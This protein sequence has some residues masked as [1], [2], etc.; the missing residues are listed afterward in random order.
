MPRRL[1]LGKS[2]EPARP[3]SDITRLVRIT[4]YEIRDGVMARVSLGTIRRGRFHKEKVAIK[5][6]NGGSSSPGRAFTASL[7]KMLEESSRTWSRVD[8]PNLVPFYGVAY[9]LFYM[10][11]LVY[12]FYAHGNIMSY[13]ENKWPGDVDKDTSD[14]TTTILRLMT[15]VAKG[16]EYLHTFNPPI[17]HG[18]VRGASIFIDDNDRA[19]LCDYGL[20]LSMPEDLPDYVFARPVGV[21]RWMAPEIMSTL[22]HEEKYGPPMGRTKLTDIYAYAM[23]ILEVYTG[24]PPFA[25]LVTDAKGTHPI[26]RIDADAVKIVLEGGRPPL[27]ESIRSIEALRDLVERAWDMTPG[28]R[29]DATEIVRILELMAHKAPEEVQLA[30]TPDPPGGARVSGKV[31][32]VFH[33]LV[34]GPWG[35]IRTSVK[36]GYE[37]L[38]KSLH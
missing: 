22:A 12:P 2:D 24:L 21:A 15:D 25:Q 27:P 13:L 8:H 4:Q 1:R 10:P 20:T 32:G 23:T 16:L 30:S 18:D 14:R 7:R 38:R 36:S 33:Y 31:Y 5:V 17:I 11:A 37:S 3:P 19:M 6:F 34:V 35:H 26:V 28:N 9:S 29:P